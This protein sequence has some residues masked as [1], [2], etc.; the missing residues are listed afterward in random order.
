[1]RV[2]K[3][4][5]IM[6]CLLILIG[7]LIC[8]VIRVTYFPKQTLLPTYEENYPSIIIFSP[9]Q[10]RS[11]ELRDCYGGHHIGFE[12]LAK[13][14][15]KQKICT[16]EFCYASP[17]TNKGYYI[18]W[19]DDDSATVSYRTYKSEE[20]DDKSTWQKVN[21]TFDN[22]SDPP[23]SQKYIKYLHIALLSGFI[24]YVTIII[25]FFVLLRR[26]ADNTVKTSPSHVSDKT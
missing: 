25:L 21:V 24:I 4:D 22:L 15:G 5:V 20:T 17:V 14:D 2:I 11:V 7:F 1:M 10:E 23:V 26:R 9:D 12:V 16:Y 19:N 6:L 18:E 3:K 13:Q 8:C